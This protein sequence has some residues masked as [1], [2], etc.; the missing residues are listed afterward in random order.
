MDRLLGRPSP[1]VDAVFAASDLMA[2]GALRALRAAGQ[3]P[4]RRGRGRLRGLGGGPLRPP[5]PPPSASPSRLG[6]Q[7]TRLLLAVSASPPAC[8]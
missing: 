6:R 8:T 4:R 1:P 7:A 3:R 2:A 5:P